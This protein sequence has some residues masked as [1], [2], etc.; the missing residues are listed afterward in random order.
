[1]LLTS[2][3]LSDIQYRTKRIKLEKVDAEIN[4]ALIPVELINESRKAVENGDDTEPIGM[5]ILMASVVDDQGNHAFESEDDYKSLP[6]AVQNEILD[7]VYDY[8]GLTE[9]PEKN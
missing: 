5:K 1:M 8:N 6:L 3:N 9:E 7:T 2:K 4:V